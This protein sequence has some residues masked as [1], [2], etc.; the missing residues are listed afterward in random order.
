M[1]YEIAYYHTD[2]FHAIGS[3][4]IRDYGKPPPVGCNFGYDPDIRWMGRW[5]LTLEQ[6]GRS[7]KAMG[8]WQ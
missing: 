8:L 1:Y 3:V 5:C 4:P 2:L 7:V 6:T